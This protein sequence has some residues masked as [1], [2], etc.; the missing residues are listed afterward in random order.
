MDSM[1]ERA[2][3]RGDPMSNGIEFNFQTR[4]TTDRGT[5]ESC[6][7]LYRLVS[8]ET[9]AKKKKEFAVRF[10]VGTDKHSPFSV[11]GRTT[12][13]GNAANTFRILFITKATDEIFNFSSFATKNP[14][15]WKEI[16]L[17]V[18]RG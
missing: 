14:R 16:S 15:Q 8:V 12:R 2:R 13:T 3:A 5:A 18:K 17:E 10:C 1:C 9:K 7:D 4:A 11:F 6:L